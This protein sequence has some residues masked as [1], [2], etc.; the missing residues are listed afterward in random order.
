M[1]CSWSISV[2]HGRTIQMNFTA[3]SIRSTPASCS[4]DYVEVCLAKLFLVS[5][6]NEQATSRDVQLTRTQTGDVIIIIIV[7][8]FA[9]N[10]QTEFNTE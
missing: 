6:Q 8:L 7:H 5:S 10:K 4:T 3:M 1:N 9:I 2:R